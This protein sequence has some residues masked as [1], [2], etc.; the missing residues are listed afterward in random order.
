MGRSTTDGLSS[1]WDIICSQC[2]RRPG[3]VIRVTRWTRVSHSLWGLQYWAP[4]SRLSAFKGRETEWKGDG[5]TEKCGVHPMGSWYWTAITGKRGGKV[6]L[7]G[8][9]SWLT[10]WWKRKALTIPNGQQSS[11]SE[12]VCTLVFRATPCGA[13]TIPL[14]KAFVRSHGLNLRPGRPLGPSFRR[15]EMYKQSKGF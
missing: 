4:F 11:K 9:I 7:V 2:P 10:N 6:E 12:Y 1:M 5:G 13:K 15:L 14:T 3:G 8:T